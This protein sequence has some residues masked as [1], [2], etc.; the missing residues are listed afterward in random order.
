MPAAVEAL[1]ISVERQ[2][3]TGSPRR[4]WGGGEDSTVRAFLEPPWALGWA[5]T[6]GP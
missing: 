6:G 4:H 1:G 2:L 3:S 5:G